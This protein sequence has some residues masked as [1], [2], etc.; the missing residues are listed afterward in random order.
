MV[1]DVRNAFLGPLVVAIA[2]SA[3]LYGTALGSN[4]ADRVTIERS[5][6]RLTVHCDDVP[7]RQ[8]LDRLEAEGLAT[9]S[10]ESAADR[11]VTLH[12]EKATLES[13]MRQ[14]L[15]QI[16][17]TNHAVRYDGKGLATFVVLSEDPKKVSVIAPSAPAAAPPATADELPPEIKAMIPPPKPVQAKEPEL[18]ERARLRALRKKKDAVAETG[19]GSLLLRPSGN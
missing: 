6:D 8:V 12:A 3:C 7:A 1:A 15:R 14:L 18:E 16:G 2:L 11:A 19:M 13:V 9:V 5:G 17:V 4:A 10:G